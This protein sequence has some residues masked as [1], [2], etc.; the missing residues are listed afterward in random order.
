MLY[1][2]K[3]KESLSKRKYSKY[4]FF[5]GFAFFLIKGLIWIG[6]FIVVGQGFVNS[7]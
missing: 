7:I 2:S 1:F 3:L 6:I 4:L 5:G